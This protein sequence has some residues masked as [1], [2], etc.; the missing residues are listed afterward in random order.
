M[1]ALEDIADASGS[2]QNA[3]QPIRRVEAVPELAA[4]SIRSS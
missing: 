3:Q 1:A 2:P 4:Q